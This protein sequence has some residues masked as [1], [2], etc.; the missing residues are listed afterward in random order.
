MNQIQDFLL[1]YLKNFDYLEC[2]II[3]D[4]EGIEIFS[5]YRDEKSP[6]KENQATTMFVAG[7]NGSN[8]N[9]IKLNQTKINCLTL[10]YDNH[11]VYLEGASN[12]FL[13]IFSKIDSNISMIKQLATDI[14]IA[15]GPL[16]LE[17]D[18]L[19]NMK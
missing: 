1:Q 5:A 4:K 13:T 2:I 15:F 8:E 10:F 6:I 7:L 3:S 14:L 9:L 16:S 12:F 17:L 19:N 18:K 11:V